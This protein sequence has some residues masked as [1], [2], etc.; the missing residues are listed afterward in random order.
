MNIKL[1]IEYDGTMYHGYQIQ[2]NGNTVQAE[3]EKAIKPLV[4]G[5]FTLYCAGR[6]DSGVHALRQVCNLKCSSLRLCVENLA[7]ALNS[8]LPNDISVKLSEE[9]SEDFHSR[10]SAKKRLYTYK[11]YNSQTRSALYNNY[12]WFVKVPLNVENMV[13]A[14]EVLQ[15]VHDFRAFTDAGYPDI[16]IRN[17]YYINI[18]SEND[19]INIHICA[20]AFTKSMVRNIVGTLVEVGRGKRSIDE[21]QVILNSLDR[22]KAGVC[23]PAKG[24][25][26]VG[27]EY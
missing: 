8:T 15:G 23:A 21:M 14:S 6:T 18:E 19:F 3:L 20:N 17:I 1:V 27:I 24:L 4:I 26:L 11:I 25:Y 10:F 2:P 22:T 16:T 7:M 13:K 5:D 9:V 12:A